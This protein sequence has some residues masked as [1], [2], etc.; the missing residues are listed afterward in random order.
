MCKY[1]T[2]FKENL[3]VT[4]RLMFKFESRDDDKCIAGHFLRIKLV[5]DE[6][7]WVVH[8]PRMKY[9]AP[10]GPGWG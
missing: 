7:S 5:R 6:I 1:W 2:V 10:Q 3:K 4:M 9:I 8:P